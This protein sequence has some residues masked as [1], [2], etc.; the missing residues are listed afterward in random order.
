MANT[1][2]ITLAKEF[3][4]S[5]ITYSD[6]KM[7]ENGGKVVYVS[8]NRAPLVLQTPEMSAPFGMQ[9]WNNDNRI[10]YTIDL[11]FKGMERR[12]GVQTFYNV[13]ETLDSKLVEDGFKN[14]ATWFKGRKITSPEVAAALYTPLIKHAKDKNT[15]ELTDKWPPTFKMTVPFKDNKF[16][17]EV[18]DDK[19]NALDL[20]TIDTKGA[21]VTSIIQFM[22]LWM[23]GGKFG[24][25]WRVLQMKIVPNQAIRGYAFKENP[26][27]KMVE[28]DLDQEPHDAK[29]IMESADVKSENG[30]VEE[31]EVAE[32]EGQIVVSDSEEDDLEPV[33]KP[34]AVAKKVVMKSRKQ[35][36]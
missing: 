17:C 32:E 12:A 26:E 2:S 25:S 23:A 21:R 35:A 30:T 7:L 20:S 3:D 8:Y 11:S 13:L 33:K 1:N 29:E 24:S 36:A 28:E 18:Y 6:V 19:R 4:V 14:Q 16:V 31:E 34:V 5:K 15:G 9:N 27:D 22:G 10:K